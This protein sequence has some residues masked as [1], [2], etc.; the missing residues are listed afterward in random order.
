MNSSFSRKSITREAR[1]Q[2]FLGSFQILHVLWFFNLCHGRDTLGTRDFF[3]RVT[4]SFVDRRPTRL[5]GSAEDTSGE[6]FRAGH[7]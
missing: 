1:I 6:G 5:R 4:K 3:S 2:I 7:F